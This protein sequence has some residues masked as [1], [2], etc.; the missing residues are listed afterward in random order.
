MMT[1]FIDANMRSRHNELT[2]NCNKRAYCDT[3]THTGVNFR[4]VMILRTDVKSNN[5]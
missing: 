3:K 5:F 1:K 2:V 4:F